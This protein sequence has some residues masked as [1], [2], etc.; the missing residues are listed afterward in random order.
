MTET[1]SPAV[2]EIIEGPGIQTWLL[3]HGPVNAISPELL[4][5]LAAAI[6]AVESRDD[7]SVVVLVSGLRVFSAGADATWM[8]RTVEEHGSA[9]LLEIFNQ[10][11]DRFRDL[12]VALRTLPVLVVAALEGHTLAGGLELAAACDL[13]FATD[14]DRV[15]VGVPEMDLF[16]AMPSGGGGA[17]FLARLMGPAAALDFILEAKPITTAKAAEL[18]IVQRIYPAGSVR[19]EAERFAAE[20]AA[21]AGRIGVSAAKRAITAGVELP[22]GDAMALDSRLHWDSM[23]RGNFLPGVDAFVAKFG[24]ARS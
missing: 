12:C 13:R 22:L 18:G 2:V 20:V 16:G 4:D 23:R 10:T 21:K 7:V 24:Q 8:A 6:R 11:M 5:A 1:A 14:S 15:Q 3:S 19:T 17:Q 9:G